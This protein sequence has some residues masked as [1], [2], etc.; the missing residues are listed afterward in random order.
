MS[1]PISSVVFD[2]GGVLIDWDP[3]HLYRKLFDDAAAMEEFLRDVCH[4]EWNEQQ[5]AG[6]RL[7][8]AV[9]EKIAEFPRYADMIK[10]YY[11]RWDE[12]LGGAIEGSVESLCALAARGTPLYALSNWSAETFPVAQRRFPFLRL[13]SG[14]VISGAERVVKPNLVIYHR[15]L[16]RYE[17]APETTLF[18]DDAPRNVQAAQALGLRTI[19]FESPAQLRREL[20][21][22]GLT[23]R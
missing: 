8:Q 15:L 22:L 21:E 16:Q 4:P 23:D 9:A 11:E 12:M 3:R 13:F 2:L 10:A 1:G 20:A 19:Q 7:H 5:D 14:I 6:R 18:I 17:L